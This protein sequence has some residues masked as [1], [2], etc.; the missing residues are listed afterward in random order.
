MSSDGRIARQLISPSTVIS[1]TYEVEYNG[2]LSDTGLESLKYGLFLDR[3]QLKLANQNINH[4][5]HRHHHHQHCLL[6]PLM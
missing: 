6:D 1:K 4:H 3:R 2:F 5:H